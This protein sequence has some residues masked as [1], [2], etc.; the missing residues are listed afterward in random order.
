[1][2]STRIVVSIL[3]AFLLFQGWRSEVYLCLTQ[4]AINKQQHEDIIKNKVFFLMYMHSTL[5]MVTKTPLT[6][7]F[8]M[9]LKWL[10]V[11]RHTFQSARVI[12]SASTKLKCKW[13]RHVHS[14]YLSRW[15]E[16]HFTPSV[17][18]RKHYCVLM[19]PQQRRCT[20]VLIY[21]SI[22]A[23]HGG[24]FGDQSVQC[25]EKME[26]STEVCG[27]SARKHWKIFKKSYRFNIF[28]ITML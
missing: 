9:C 7:D 11:S 17:L 5:S 21:R 6:F 15:S 18:Y 25:L 27:W 24:C 3:P 10:E 4:A 19:G 23:W 14:N 22:N 28:K 26:R 8:I 16:T 13:P 12:S 20:E 2:S 1:M